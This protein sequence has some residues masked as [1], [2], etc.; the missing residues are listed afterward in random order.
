[1]DPIGLSSFVRNPSTGKPEEHPSWVPE[2][3]SSWIFWLIPLGIG[4]L[5]LDDVLRR[6][7]E[8][9]ILLS[10]CVALSLAFST[11]RNIQVGKKVRSS[12]VASEEYEKAMARLTDDRA[13]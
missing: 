11:W 2:R 10:G 4:G 3:V 13:G 1:M 8:N 5:L 9:V 6:G 12:K 7:G